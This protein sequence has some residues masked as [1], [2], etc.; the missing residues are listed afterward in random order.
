ME[1]P[2]CSENR[3]NRCRA[4][5]SVGSR[6]V[7]PV[8]VWRTSRLRCVL[9]LC[10]WT[11]VA[12]PAMAGTFEIQSEQSRVRF[13]IGHNDYTKPVRGRFANVSGEIDYEASAP[14]A[15]TAEVVIDV[16]SVDTDNAYRDG[17]LRESF[18]EADRYPQILFR[19]GRILPGEG[20]VEGELTMKGVTRTVTL[21]ISNVR[22]LVDE[23]GKRVLTAR[24]T[25]RLNR[26]D[27]GIQGDPERTAGLGKLLGHIQQGLDE[28]IDDDVEIS[29]SL[30]AHEVSGSAS[31]ELLAVL[32]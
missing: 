8:C 10:A 2:L 19:L 21:A 15:A 30:V 20:W 12:T 24:A 32:D 3:I 17:H 16:A 9:I 28:F 5:V 22:E 18:F 6:P 23:R 31:G 11:L 1:N 25:T 4:A 14:T 29:I 26:R 13:E 27:F 7:A